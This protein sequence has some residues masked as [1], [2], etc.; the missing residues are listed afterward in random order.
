MYKYSDIILYPTM[1]MQDIKDKYGIPC[2]TKQQDEFIK[3]YQNGC[4]TDY[5]MSRVNGIG[6]FF[7]LNK[8]ARALLLSGELHKVSSECCKYI[9]HKE[10]QLFKPHH[11][12]LL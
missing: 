7:G 5:L 11:S 3:R 2:F 1:K 9:T 6:T 4:R 8:K 12:Q 10:I